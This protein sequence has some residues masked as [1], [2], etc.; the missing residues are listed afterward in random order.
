MR[1]WE[2]TPCPRGMVVESKRYNGVVEKNKSVTHWH[3]TNHLVVSGTEAAK[4]N[5]LTDVP[6]VFPLHTLPNAMRRTRQ[7]ERGTESSKAYDQNKK[8]NDERNH[9]YIIR[10]ILQT[11]VN[12]GL[13][14]MLCKAMDWGSRITIPTH[15]CTSNHRFKSSMRD[16]LQCY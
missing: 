3:T 8:V 12:L 16:M 5:N 7:T 2:S 11:M 13:T 4:W 9:C 10:G 6:S 15:T 1:F 14:L